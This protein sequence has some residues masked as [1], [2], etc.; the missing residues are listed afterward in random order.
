MAHPNESSIGW[1]LA[2]TARLHRFH[3]NKKLTDMGLFAGQEQVL[4]ALD[5]Q[6]ALTIGELASNLRVRG[7]TVSK[8]VTRLAALGF[9]ERES[10]GE[11]RRSVRRTMHLVSGI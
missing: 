2:Q 8:A 1:V 3:L 4:Q 10:N 9:V 7:P 5:G 6:G 11:D